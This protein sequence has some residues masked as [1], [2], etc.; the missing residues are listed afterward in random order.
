MLKMLP[1]MIKK[2]TKLKLKMRTN[3]SFWFALKNIIT[4]I[5]KDISCQNSKKE[6]FKKFIYRIRGTK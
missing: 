5:E 4:K 3:L 6:P 2:A 1:K